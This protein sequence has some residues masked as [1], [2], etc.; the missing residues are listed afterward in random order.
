M[1]STLFLCWVC[2]TLI[3]LTC[4]LVLNRYGLVYE[5]EYESYVKLS[6]I[7]LVHIPFASILLLRVIVTAIKGEFKKKDEHDEPLPPSYGGQVHDW[8]EYEPDDDMDQDF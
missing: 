6:Y 7:P 8:M 2:F 3:S 4:V 5:K 1:L